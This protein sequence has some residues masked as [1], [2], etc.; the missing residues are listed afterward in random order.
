MILVIAHVVL[1]QGNSSKF[2]SI[3]K[4][5][6][7]ETRKEEGN[8]SYT[9]LADTKNCCRYTFVEEWESKDALDK[10]MKT[11][12]FITFDKSIETLLVEPLSIN[13]YNANK[14]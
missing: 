2:L 9:L 14:L 10:H 3:S 11:N 5:C 13:L 4:N 12:H 1:K 8:I 6:I 7:D